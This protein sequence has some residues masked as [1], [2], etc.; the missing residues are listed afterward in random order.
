MF[1]QEV[2]SLCQLLAVKTYYKVKVD[3]TFRNRLLNLLWIHLRII[4]GIV[5]DREGRARWTTNDP[6]WIVLVNE[7]SRHLTIGFL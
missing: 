6:I 7:R 2:L 5:P 3:L 1:V 4:H